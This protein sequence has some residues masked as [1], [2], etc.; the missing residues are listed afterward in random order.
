MDAPNTHVDPVRP[1]NEQFFDHGGDVGFAGPE[2]NMEAEPGG[3]ETEPEDDDR[4]DPE[5]R[6]PEEL[7]NPLNPTSQQ[8]RKHMLTHMPYRSWCVHCVRGR[9]KCRSHTRLDEERAENLQVPHVCVDYGFL[10]DDEHDTMPILVTKDRKTRYLYSHVVPCKG[11]GHPY[12]VRRLVQ[13]LEGM[14]Y[15]DVKVIMKS[16]QENAL[17]DLVRRAASARSGDTV[18]ELVPRQSSQSAGVVER[19]IQ[20]VFGTIRSVF[21]AL[22][23]RYG[24]VNQDHPILPWLVQHSGSLVS[25]YEVGVDGKT[26]DERLKGKTAREP[27]CEFGECV[28]FKLP[29]RGGKRAK[30]MPRWEDGVWLGVK[31][32][33]GEFWIGTREGITTSRSVQRK[34]DPEK[35]NRFFLDEFKG[36]PWDLRQEQH[37][38]GEP[39]YP[40]ADAL[41][42]VHPE[43]APAPEFRPPTSGPRRCK[44]TRGIL[45][46]FGYTKNCAGCDAARCG[47]EPRGHSESCRER[48]TQEMAADEEFRSRVHQAEA[49]VKQKADHNRETETEEPPPSKRARVTPKANDNDEPNVDTGAASSDSGGH[50]SQD[51]NR[52]PEVREP[53]QEEPNHE[54]Q[55]S[56]EDEPAREQAQGLPQPDEADVSGGAQREIRKRQ[57]GGERQQEEEERPRLRRRIEEITQIQQE[58]MAMGHTKAEVVELFS[59]ARVTKWCRKFRLQ[60]GW[61][62][63]L[64]TR[65]PRDGVAWDF[66]N[67]EIQAKAIKYIENERP[68]LVVGSPECRAFSTLQNLNYPHMDPELVRAL[69]QKAIA[70]VEFC[71]RVYEL[72]R[73][74]GRYFV[75]EHPA[76]ATSW[77][78]RCIQELSEKAG[79]RTVLGHMCQFGMQQHDEEGMG[80]ILKPTKFMTNSDCIAQQLDRRCEGKGGARHRHIPLMG[81][82][83]TKDAAIYPD[84]LC[85]AILRGLRQEVE[86][87]RGK[88]I[89]G[90]GLICPEEE[91]GAEGWLDTE[92]YQKFWDSSSGAALPPNLVKTAREEEMR[93]L[94]KHRVYDIVPIDECWRETGR[95]PV[96]TMWLDTNKGDQKTPEIRSRWVGK[97]F[98][99]SARDDVFAATPPLEM[100]KLLFSLAVSG[101]ASSGKPRK[102]SFIDIKRA[103][104]HAPVRQVIYVKLP[105][106][107]GQPHMCGRLNMSLYGTR[108][109]ARNWQIAVVEAM[110]RLGFT[111][112]MSSPCLFYHTTRDLRCVVHGD[113]FTTLGDEVELEWF[114][115]ELAKVFSL[116]LRGVLGPEPHDLKEIRILNRVVAWDGSGIWYETD[117][118][119]SEII[120]EGLGLEEGNGVAAAVDKENLKNAQLDESPTYLEG[121]AAKNFR[122]L[123]AR[124]NYIAQDR[125]DLQFAA[126]EACRFMAQPTTSGLALLKRLGRY[127]KRHPRMVQLFEYQATPSELTVWVDSDWGGCLRSRRSTSGGIIKHG[128]HVIKSWSSTQATVATS[129]GEAE[130]YAA[131]KGGSVGLGLRGMAGEIGVELGIT[132][133]SDSAAAIGVARRA[134]LGKLRH[135]DVS[136]L[137]L[138]QHVDAGSIRLR[139]V[140]GDS[141][142]ADILTKAVEA[143]RLHQHTYSL[144]GRFLEGR[145]AAAP[146]LA[147]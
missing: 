83:R 69:V 136:L 57:S 141:N 112:A 13:N 140:G 88:Y 47:L 101:V 92:D 14:G 105:P 3:N 37:R 29:V 84:Q 56:H 145:A 86:R 54:P 73:V 63:D 79:V 49:R 60:P 96:D 38:E 20:S 114:Y 4:D 61:A 132:M 143:W 138:Q 133:F 55:G 89:M 65:D 2:E 124:A 99:V 52:G 51:P 126:K 75:H 144:G 97:E 113:D 127:V 117:Q 19:G 68:W 129:S 66:D 43:P 135:V 7:P 108:A 31:E 70:H 6:E 59:P 24:K 102:L 82:R 15:K 35:W 48:I 9:G 25:R 139:K 103:C 22:Q 46:K 109:A 137:W 116:K 71:T 104:F 122:G 125:F 115:Q 17:E 45:H 142:P 18:V 93:E 67:P 128:S 119:H 95:R 62:L 111:V 77:N 11:P 53:A 39:R 100:L 21:D 123:A 80:H 120:V 40:R 44:I 134:G 81:G 147:K 50:A 85:I 94:R 28:Q 130:Y 98:N 8:V 34:P 58:L 12:C 30:L 64:T 87:R 76:R 16:D 33:S 10:G 90:V 146:E 32:E 41:A 27:L 107:E 23:H 5:G 36:L 74:S 118:R 110:Q 106:E 72:Q 26:A 42:E 121:D 131:V 91:A 1:A 78:L